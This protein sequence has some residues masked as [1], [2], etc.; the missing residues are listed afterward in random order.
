MDQKTTPLENQEIRQRETRKKLDKEGMTRTETT[1]PDCMENH[2]QTGKAKSG[3]TL[4]T[5]V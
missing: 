3:T 2:Y 5:T 1:N 4:I